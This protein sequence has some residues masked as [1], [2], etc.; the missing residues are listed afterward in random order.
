MDK[1][2]RR[3]ILKCRHP[4]PD[5][6]ESPATREKAVKRNHQSVDIA[7]AAIVWFLNRGG[8]AMNGRTTTNRG[9]IRRA[10]AG[11][12][13]P[14]FPSSEGANRYQRTG[15]NCPAVWQALNET[16]PK[17]TSGG[18]GAFVVYEDDYGQ[19]MMNARRRNRLVRIASHKRENFCP[20]P[21]AT[22]CW[23][24]LMEQKTSETAISG[25]RPQASLPRRR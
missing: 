19:S 22:R 14:S 23:K 6:M 10:I 9:R 12:V 3:Q 15:Y 2:G 7:R 13:A 25:A 18:R 8:R 5:S 17:F 16:G 1:K 21:G 4:L 24:T 11:N 20:R